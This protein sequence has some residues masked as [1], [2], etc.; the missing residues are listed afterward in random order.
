MKFMEEKQRGLFAN[1]WYLLRRIIKTDKLLFFFM[2]LMVPV[3]VILPMAMA[4]LPKTIIDSIT[5]H[6]LL[7]EF[8]YNFLI[9]AVVISVLKVLETFLDIILSDRAAHQRIFYQQHLMIKQ[10]NMLYQNR[11]TQEG[12]EKYTQAFEMLGGDNSFSQTFAKDFSTLL[13]SL[14]GILA[15]GAII[16]SIKPILIL[17][18]AVS[19][20]VSYLYGKLEVS[21]KRKIDDELKTEK[22]KMKYLRSKACSYKY[23]KD[24]KLYK[25]ENWLS[26]SFDDTLSVIVRGINKLTAI[27]FLGAVITGLFIFLRDGLAYFYLTAMV[28]TKQIELGEFVFLFSI[29]QSFSNW[30]LGIVNQIVTMKKNCTQ[31]DYF[32]NYCEADDGVNRSKGLPLPEKYDIEFKNVSFRYNENSNYI[33][34]NLNLK[35]KDKEKIAIVG[36]NG[37]GKTT[38]TGLMMQLLKPTEGEI[39][40]DGKNIEEYNIEDYYGLFSTVFQD[41]YMEPVTVK[42]FITCTCNEDFGLKNAVKSK[43]SIDEEKYQNAIKNSGMDKIIETLPNKENTHLMKSVY[44]DGVDM[45]GGQQQILVLARALYKNAAINILDEPTAALDPIKEEEI[46]NNYNNMTKDKT[47]VFISHRLASTRFCDRILFIENGEILEEGS[48]DDL[49]A[50]GGRYK[51]MFDIQSYYYKNNISD[52]EIE[53]NETA[54]AEIGGEL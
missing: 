18:I 50:K 32:R 26:K 17:V 19:T 29:I 40:I 16:V 8:L 25:I 6:L 24:I 53:E 9:V 44:P 11:A 22:T 48:H 34:K 15:F 36:T 33:F 47:A 7:K 41:V 49:L 52:L 31:V 23:A 10:W 1:S 5:Q 43:I 45:S 14:M 54:N 35:I 2:L 12:Q 4:Y 21:K 13:L 30:L 38:L 3:G 37:A 27:N 42:E 20:F 46:Y 51:E 39:L 28:L